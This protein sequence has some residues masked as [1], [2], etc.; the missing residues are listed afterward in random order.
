MNGLIPT[1]HALTILRNF[2]GQMVSFALVADLPQRIHLRW[3]EAFFFAENVNDKL[4][5]LLAHCFIGRTNRFGRGF[6][7]CGL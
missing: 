1:Q 2:G 6:S 5:L 3:G 7:P 4:P